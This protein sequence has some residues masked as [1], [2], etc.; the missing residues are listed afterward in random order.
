MLAV[1]NFISLLESQKQAW[2]HYHPQYLDYSCSTLEMKKILDVLILVE[3]DL[4][5]TRHNGIDILRFD[6]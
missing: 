3:D 4:F 1:F 6:V 5:H 2:Q